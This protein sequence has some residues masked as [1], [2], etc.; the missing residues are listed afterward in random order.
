MSSTFFEARGWSVAAQ[1]VQALHLFS[2][3]WIS[4]HVTLCLP[5]MCV[6]VCVRACVRACV[7]EC[8]KERDKDREGKTASQRERD[9]I[10]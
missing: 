6:C 2:L 3:T 4:V 10:D 5:L 7:R 9:L 8:V 1:I